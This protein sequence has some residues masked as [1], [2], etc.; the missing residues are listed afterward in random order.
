MQKF[1]YKVAIII[2]IQLVIA[3][4]HAFR[5]GQIFEGNLYKLYYSYFSDLILPF[6]IYFLLSANE[7]SIPFLRYWRV[8]ALAVFSV[9]T[10]AEILQY[11]G[12]YALGVTFDLVDIL[13]YGCGVI[14][15]AIVDTQVFSRIFK[16]WALEN[17]KHSGSLRL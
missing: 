6:G 15:A 17:S 13:M 7:Y 14:L 11:F 5:L 8:K 4:V 12:I 10:L 16:F 2:S 1:A 3:A 9:A